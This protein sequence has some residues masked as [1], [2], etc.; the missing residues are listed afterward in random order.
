MSPLRLTLPVTL[1]LISTGFSKD[2]L[3]PG[4]G[5]DYLFEGDAAAGSAG[6]ALDGSWNHNS[7]SDHWDGTA[8]GSGNPGGITVVPV[9]GEPGNSA[10]LMV[11]AVTASGTNNNRRFA[12]IHD[13]SANEGIP[14]TFLDDGATLAFR[15]RLPGSAPDLPSAPDGLNPHSGSKG[16]VNLR[17]N[18]G[19]ISFALGIAGTDSSYQ[20]DGMLISDANATFFHALDPTAWNE[21]WVTTEQN[22]ADASLYDLRVYRNGSIVPVIVRSIKPSTTVDASYPYISLQLSATNQKAA[23]E[24]DYIAFKDGLHLPN[25]SDNDALPDTWELIHFPDLGQSGDDDAEPDGLTNNQEFNLGTDPNLAD[26][27]GDGLNDAAEFNQHGSD[28]AL[29]DSDGDGLDDGAEI[30]GVPATNP[31][32]ADSDGDELSDGEE[33]LTHGTDPTNADSDGDGYKD[34]IEVAFGYD[35]NDAGSTPTVQTLDN[36]LI[37]EFMADN[38]G[39]RLDSDGES[40]DWIEL[41]NPTSSPVNLAG[42]YLTDNQQVPNNWALPPIIMQP[43]SYLLVFAS[44]KD[45]NAAN[46]ELHTNFKLTSGGEYLALT[47]DDGAEGFTVLSEYAATYPKQQQGISYGLNPDSL[48]HGYLRVPSPGR[49][50]GET[51]KGFVGDTAFNVDRGFFDAA[52][53][54]EITSSTEGAIIRYTT[55]GSTPS[56]TSGTVYS[57]PVR[58]NKTTVIRAMAYNTGYFP[59]NVDTH[60]YLFL[61]DVRTQYANGS[62]PPG[63]PSG[64]SNGQ[65]FNYGMDPNVTSQYSAH[66]M[67]DALSSIPSVSLVTDQSNLTGG[68]GIYTNPG[69]HGKAW[70]RPASFEILDT[71]GIKDSVQSNCGLRV[72][73]G[74]SRSKSNPK[75]SFRLFFRNE[76]GAGKLNYPLFEADGVDQFDKI[77]L[78]TSQNYS[79]AYR[80]NSQNT[81]LREVL[82][83]DLQGAIGQPYTKSRYYHLYLNGIYWGL[84]MTDERAEATFGEAYFGGQSD[85]YDT[86]KSGGSSTGYTTEATDGNMNA[87]RVL[88]QM[89]RDQNNSPSL[90][91]FM[92]MQGLNADGSRNSQLP[93]YLDVNNLID[94][95]IVLGYTANADAPPN[96]N[97]WFSVR[98]RVSNDM[99]FQFFVHDGEHSLGA[100]GNSGDRINA[101]RGS[102]DRS[103]FSKSNPMLIRLDIEER[104]P[105]FRL[106]FADRVHK[107]FFNF[108]DGLMVREHV[109]DTLH[110][111]RRTVAAVIIAEAARWGN[112]GLGEQQW[113]NAANDV[114]RFINSRR[115][116]FF[117]HLRSANLYPNLAAP[118]YSQHGGRVVAGSRIEVTAPLG[119]IRVYYMIGTGDSNTED[120]QDDLDPR[121]LGGAVNPLAGTAQVGNGESVARDFMTSGH[122]WKYLDDGTDQGTAWRSAD[123]DD[124]GWSEGP[125]ELGYA[126]GDEATRVAYIDTDPLR[127]GIQRNATTYFRT[128]VEIVR[129]S[130]YSY[131][132][133]KLKYDDAAA[134]YANGVEILRTTNLPANAAFNTFANRSTPNEHLFFNFQIPSSRFIAGVNSLAVE[135]HNASSSSSDIS[136]DMILRG[137]IDTGNGDATKL[138]I[139]E[140]I[141]TPVWLK[142]RSYNTASGEWSALN[143]AFFTTA[144]FATAENVLISEVHYHPRKADTGELLINPGFDKDDFEFIEVMNISGGE[145]DLGGSAFVLIASGDHL[146]GVEF[147]FPPGTL[148]GPGQRLV[149]AANSAAFTARYPDVPVAGDYSNRLDNNGEWIT[150]V[151]AGGNIIDRFRYNDASPWPEQADGDGPSLVLSDPESAPDPADP[152]SWTAGLPDGGS[153]GAADNSVP[154]KIIKVTSAGGFNNLASLTITFSSVPNQVYA[155]ERSKNL[156]TWEQ[157][158]QGN[159]TV[160]GGSTDFTDTTPLL[161]ENAVFYRVRKVE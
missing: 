74:F 147:K 109:M 79:W 35:P 120:W 154:L 39:A 56:A 68:N 52:F 65:Q 13:L 27:D 31:L 2:Y 106:R 143:Q 83:R 86:V 14:A 140:A 3:P 150:L 5:W 66:Q 94:Y 102:G 18:A 71:G 99:G 97:N 21:F 132:V 16:M 60:T 105:E 96:N 23:V 48:E 30:N 115:D 53:D 152:A 28:P 103:N 76:Y 20:Q 88:W 70:E 75:H 57:K 1:L 37:N 44:G 26:S 17:S 9:S 146:E 153:P 137:E 144:P 81:F 93:V 133:V 72:R 119:T 139:P 92:R 98:N 148:I 129:P 126:E 46:S 108:P 124:S 34:G 112:S 89:A 100:G 145:V 91:R 142:S 110:A 156:L 12:L 135:I 63:W 128:D 107:R 155:I 130:G 84:Y 62:A 136:F 85:D 116:N 55:D 141:T 101:G 42:H 22:S 113:I 138:I 54:L 77:D 25:D 58:I 7:N 51:F 43:G 114:D 59:T 49:A 159:A 158:W 149:V 157:L 50:N 36:L 127:G 95:A 4:G 73:G 123:H 87:W 125:S 6:A 104:T 11:D 10:L 47:R 33:V 121:L 29:A 40:S 151:D 134:V 82:C 160:S 38:D 117:S 8:P 24:I 15:L 61:D 45:R 80:G 69:S 161:G 78:R 90:E 19:R 131:F 64:S 118:V 32:V 41:W 111:R 67:M 122:V